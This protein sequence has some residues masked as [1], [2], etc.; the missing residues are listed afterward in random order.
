MIL[1][2]C[3]LPDE[4]KSLHCSGM[5]T[6]GNARMDARLVDHRASLHEFVDK[7]SRLSGAQWIRPRAEGK[8][9]PVQEARH[10]VLTYDALMRDLHDETRLRL[11]G[12]PLRRWIWRLFGL[13]TIMWRKRIP[14]AV[15]APR[16]VRPAEESTPATELLPSLLACGDRFETTFL[17]KLAT[18]PKR[19]VTHPF[20][21]GLTL[22]QTITL[23]AVHN[24]HHAAF[25]PT[26][27]IHFGAPHAVLDTSG[28]TTGSGA[29]LR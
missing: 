11:K 19:R 12:T 17:E 3:P 25:L 5:Q 26:T 9:A 10:L 15:R 6:S 23:L 21:G 28:P 18:E 13:T 27:P 14:V 1:R 24:R 7:A 2:L 8:W 4:R 22:D 29:G 16:E 20:F